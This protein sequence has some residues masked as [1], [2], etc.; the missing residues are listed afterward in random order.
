MF[1][2]VSRTRVPYPWDPAAPSWFLPVRSC[3]PVL[4]SCRHVRYGVQNSWDSAA[5]SWYIVGMLD[6]LFRNRDNLQPQPRRHVRSGTVCTPQP[7]RFC[8]DDLI[9]R[10]H[11]RSDVPYPRDHAAPSWYLI[12]MWNYCSFPVRSCSPTVIARRHVRSDVPYLWNTAVPSLYLV[13]ML[14]LLFR[15]REIMQPRPDTS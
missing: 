15:T 7:V 12:C 6:Q 5:S 4:I 2:L 11:V 13:G 3:S 10:K 8:S 9:P 1:N 14:D